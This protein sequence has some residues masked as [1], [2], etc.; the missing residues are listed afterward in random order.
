MHECFAFTLPTSGLWV[1]VMQ[2]VYSNFIHQGLIWCRIILL[3]STVAMLDCLHL[4][5]NVKP[6]IC[7]WWFLSTST[8]YLAF[9]LDFGCVSVPCFFAVLFSQVTGWSGASFEVWW[10]LSTTWVTTASPFSLP[11]VLQVPKQFVLYS[12]FW[13]SMRWR[14]SWFYSEFINIKHKHIWL[15]TFPKSTCPSRFG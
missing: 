7:I 4:L 15:T 11:S 1:E 5:D 9:W 12:L 2:W 3:Y 13:W 14:T 10:Y 8:P 6:S